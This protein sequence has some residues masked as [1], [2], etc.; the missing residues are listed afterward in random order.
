MDCGVLFHRNFTVAKLIKNG[1]R[2][3][4]CSTLTSDVSKTVNK[5]HRCI[6]YVAKATFLCCEEACPPDIAHC[7][8]VLNSTCHVVVRIIWLWLG[9]ISF[10]Q[11]PHLTLITRNM[12][13][14]MSW[15]HLW[16]AILF[17]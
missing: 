4:S 13:L 11:K 8:S 5:I 14:R 17:P 6:I 10:V 15:W 3:S 7:D 12:A 2:T 16:L 1:S 9:Q